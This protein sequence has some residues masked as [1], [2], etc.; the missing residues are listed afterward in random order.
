MVGYSSLQD[1]LTA[2]GTGTLEQMGIDNFD[3]DDTERNVITLLG[4]YAG[5]N[6]MN[7]ALES[8]FFLKGF[9]WRSGEVDPVY[10]GNAKLVKS[11]WT[12]L[13]LGL[14]ALHYEWDENAKAC[15]E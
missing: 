11:M 12:T 1:V 14:K 9:N 10:D 8:E 2:Y 4:S 7:T 3:I 13:K 5:S 15:I 6:W